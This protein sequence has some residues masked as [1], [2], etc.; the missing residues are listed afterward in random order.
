MRRLPTVILFAIALAAPP[1]DAAAYS[2]YYGNYCSSCHG[3]TV[4]TC[5]GCHAHGTHSGTAK[6]DIHITGTLDKTVYAPGATVTVTID[7]GYRS[8]W[9]RVRLL[10]PAMHELA[11]SSCPGGKGA[12]STTGYPVT[13][14]APAPTTPGTY[15]WAVTWYGNAQHEGTG[16]SF[17]AGT[18][19]TLK[20]GSFTPDPNNANHGDQVVALAPFTVSSTAQPA[21]AIAPTS[22]AFSSVAAGTT[23]S[24]SFTV[25]NSGSATLAGTLA[26]GAG[27]SAEYRFSPASVSV[28]PGGSQAISV[29]YAPIDA[30]TDAGSIVVTTN[31]PAHP[32]VSVALSGVGVTAGPALS[33]SG[34]SLSFGSVE[35]GASSSLTV[36]LQSTGASSLS[37]ASVGRCATPASSPDF[38]WSTPTPAPFG[39]A[40]GQSVTLTVTFTPSGAGAETGCLVVTSDDPQHPTVQLVLSGSGVEAAA[41][42]GG[43]GGSGGCGTTSGP[44]VATLLLVALGMLGP[45]R[46]AVRVRASSRP[47]DGDGT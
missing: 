38:G 40:A 4:S 8:G 20:A 19:A 46:R 43:S 32:T 11:R 10:D 21:V 7:G 35:V 34:S 6:T 31:D 13:L 14:T 23:A 22:I 24:R 12:C 25:S 44:D 17:G 3:S 42:A 33:L 28:A 18:S 30:T 15:T 39:V 2:S 37:V 45:A 9:L 29:T 27:T 16:A 41:T 36:Q 47:R 26:L 5:N 1:R